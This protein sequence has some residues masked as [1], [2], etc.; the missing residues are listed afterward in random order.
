MI[1]KLTIGAVVYSVEEVPRLI[2]SG[3]D[4]KDVY[5]NG[6]IQYN[7]TRI[8]VEAESNDQIKPQI[9]MHEALHGILEQAGITDEPEN[10]IVALGYGLIALLRDNP[11]F[12]QWIM[13][14]ADDGTT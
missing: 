7:V 8:R 12:V 5:C 1:N 9:V 14:A 13:G 2:V 4:G 11:E 6:N 3:S 10:M